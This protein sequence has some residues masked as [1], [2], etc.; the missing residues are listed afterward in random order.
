MENSSQEAGIENL[1]YAKEL[2]V[3]FDLNNL[4]SSNVPQAENIFHS[5]FFCLFKQNFN[6]LDNGE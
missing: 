4:Q 6:Q 2:T 3:S 5:F 1:D